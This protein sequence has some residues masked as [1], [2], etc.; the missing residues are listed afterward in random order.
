VLLVALPI[1]AGWFVAR[2]VNL[3]L[4]WARG[5]AGSRVATARGPVASDRGTNVPDAPTA[6]TPEADSRPAPGPGQAARVAHTDG[7][8]VVLRTAPR[9]D[10]RVPRGLLEGPRVSVLVQPDGGWAHVRGD[11]GMEGWV[12]IEFLAASD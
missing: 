1:A 12:P 6:A 10:A 3:D 7:Q 5:S 2:S 11:N 8:G 9:E 4:S